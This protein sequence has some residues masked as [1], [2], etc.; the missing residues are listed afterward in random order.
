MFFMC[1]EFQVIGLSLSQSLVINN[2]LEL[3]REIF[4]TQLLD[5]PFCFMVPQGVVCC[6][7]EYRFH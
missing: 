2:D 5:A 7:V 6:Y 1:I 4:A 3:M